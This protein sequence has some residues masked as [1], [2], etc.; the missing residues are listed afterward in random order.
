VLAIARGSSGVP[1]RLKRGAALLAAAGAL[2][3][4][5]AAA[6]RRT[7]AEP[8][9]LRHSGFAAFARGECG[10]AG[11]NLYVSAAGNVE[12]IHRWDLDR[13][14]FIDLVFTQDSNSRTET[15]DAIVYW[16][17]REGFVSLFPPMWEERARFSVLESILRNQGRFTL[18]PT[19][20]GGRCRI[21]DLNRDGYPDIVFVNVIHNYTHLLPAYIYWGG[22]QGYGPERRTELPTLFAHGVDVADLDGDAYPDLVLANRGD[23]ELETRWGPQDDRESWVYWGGPAGFSVAARTSLATHNALDCAVGDYDGD[24]T[25]DV[26][27]LNGPRNEAATLAIYY[28]GTR[29]FAGARRAE[30]PAPGGTALRALRLRAG[31]RASDLAVP[32]SGDASTIFFGGGAAGLAP[33]RAVRLPSSDA[34]DAAAADLD[35]DGFADL[36]LAN[37]RGESSVVYWGSA[38]GFAA[39]RRVLLPTLGAEGVAVDDLDGNGYPDVVFA[40]SEASERAGASIGRRPSATHDVPSYVYWGSA[41]GL[42]PYRRSEVQGFGAAAVATG[43]LD[44]DGRKDILLVNQLSGPLPNRLN[45]L[46]FRGNPQHHYSSASML[47]LYDVPDGQVTNAD[48]DDDGYPEL[49]LQS[50]I[51]WGGQSGYADDKRTVLKS[52]GS[53]AGSRVA[54]L[55]RDG[56]LDLV[57]VEIDR[58]QRSAGRIF[59]GGRDGYSERR[60]ESFPIPGF[61]I[62]PTLADL[63]RDG[64]LD[65]VAPDIKGRSSIIRGGPKGFAGSE[66]VLL[67]TDSTDMAQAADL[68]GDGWLDLVFC[69]GSNL[70]KKTRKA[71]SYVYFGGPGGFGAREPVKLEGYTALEVGIADLDR[72]GHLDLVIG[73]YSAGLVR[74]LP[75]FIYWGGAE[76]TFTNARR[77]EL[78]AESSAGIQVLDLD[79]NGYPDIV[80]HNHIKDGKHDFGSY[81]YWGGPEGF[82]ISRRS[83]LPTT[84]THMSCMLD[85][86]NVYTRKLEEV[87]VSEPLP[88]PAGARFGRLHWKADTPFGTGVSFQVRSGTTRVEL[89]KSAWEGPRGPGTS[90]K[91]SGGRLPDAAARSPWLQYRAVLA[92]PDA[93]NS[94]VLREVALECD[95]TGR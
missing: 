32:S 95:G 56:Y 41:D 73:N 13:D 50:M 55:N 85:P 36:V 19:R 54:D 62:Y 74:T 39:E 75:V 63:D 16:G 1:A 60:T 11:R 84:G 79:R 42:A 14:G 44:G 33:E 12:M 2:A 28:G 3:L 88:A 59:W 70:E 7:A 20:G 65:L 57:Y 31:A 6:A 52:P 80:V 35:R 25:P 23:Y 94:P 67:R 18:L 38:A 34:A 53:L 89:D 92:A 76:G 21:A 37:R 40:N 47:R 51:C 24:G 9:W 15:P 5:A 58:R 49:V 68:D 87:Y 4:G 86:G 43:D 69:G 77:T 30:V 81:I 8:V 91:T 61:V 48:L 26:A 45:A 78:P 64:W 10:D 90:F 29:R 83:H 46:V 93:G 22:P 72:D 17:A 71:E 82:A 66:P 27:F